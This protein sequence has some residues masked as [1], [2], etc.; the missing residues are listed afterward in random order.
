MAW[1]SGT[2]S[3]ANMDAGTDSPASAR[4]DIKALADLV[5]LIRAE[6]ATGA[7]V[8][9]T[10][11]DGAGSGLDAD[12]LDGNDGAYYLN[13]ANLSAGLLALARL[14]ATLTGKDA[15][16]VDGIHA[17]AAAAPNIL[18]ALNS[19]SKLPASITGDAASIGGNAPSYFATAA[20]AHEITMSGGF[21]GGKLRVG[22]GST[23][24]TLTIQVGRSSALEAGG[25]N[26]S[27][28]PFYST[29]QYCIGVVAIP[30]AAGD[31]NGSTSLVSFDNSG[32][33]FKWNEWNSGNFTWAAAYVA[34][35]YI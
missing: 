32:A 3:T 10:S 26:T 23:S 19:S 17:A 15:D 8:F 34:V 29:F 31:I 5:N 20:H 1:P 2:I 28:C 30:Y 14:P 33:T 7:T 25:G 4:A 27:Y 11:N 12:L 35:G 6:V 13:A 21:L 16:S 24:A 9:S 18:L 22:N